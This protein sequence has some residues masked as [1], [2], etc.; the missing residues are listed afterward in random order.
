LNIS[1]AS[2]EIGAVIRSLP[3]KKISGANGFTAKFYQ[4]FK[5]ELTLIFLKLFHKIE[6]ERMLPN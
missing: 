1:I 4:A 6:R 2:S 5:E 3:T